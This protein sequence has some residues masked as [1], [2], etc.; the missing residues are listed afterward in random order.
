MTNNRMEARRQG[1]LATL[2]ATYPPG[3][4]G[5]LEIRADHLVV[6]FKENPGVIVGLSHMGEDREKEF[7]I[8]CGLE[9]FVAG[10]CRTWRGLQGIDG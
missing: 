10:A 2:T 8:P 9:H 4:F 7:V 1:T 3:R 5:A 6:T